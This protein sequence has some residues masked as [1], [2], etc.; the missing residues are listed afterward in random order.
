MEGRAGQK[1]ALKAHAEEGRAL[2]AK[3]LGEIEQLE[4][5][6]RDQRTAPRR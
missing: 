4:A 6:L 2:L 3:N 5:R 1:P